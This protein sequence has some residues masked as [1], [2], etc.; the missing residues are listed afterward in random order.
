MAY[1][2][3]E[4]PPDNYSPSYFRGFVE[5]IREAINFL[6]RNN[7]PNGLEGDIIQEKS[8]PGN[9]LSYFPRITIPLVATTG[10]V[11]NI[12][13][14]RLGGWIQ[15][16]KD[17]YPGATK[18]NLEFNAGGHSSA[19]VRLFNSSHN[20]LLETPTFGTSSVVHIV[21]DLID[22]PEGT[23][24]VYAYINNPNYGNITVYNAFLHIYFGGGN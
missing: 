4:R 7:F 23:T 10:D 8:I 9:R 2:D 21:T 15:L 3:S 18:M 24:A 14:V 11:K 1:L 19:R 12:L 13:D 16:G 6:D 20:I 17:I 22:V 5:R